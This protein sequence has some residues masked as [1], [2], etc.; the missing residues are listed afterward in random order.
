MNELS[1]R[2]FVTTSNRLQPATECKPEAAEAGIAGLNI[3][4][5]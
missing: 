2:D 3:A 1:I 5:S 4:R